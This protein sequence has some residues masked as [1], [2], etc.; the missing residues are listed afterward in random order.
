[1]SNALAIATVAGAAIL[2]WVLFLYRKRKLKVDQALLWMLVSI[3]MI[4]L[5]TWTG[6]LVSINLVVGAARTSDVVLAAFVAFLIVVSI[7]YSMKIS[8]LS[9]QTRKVA[10]EIAVLKTMKSE[11]NAVEALS[12]GRQEES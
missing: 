9:E 12:G 6:L 3:A 8:E 5:S 11:V 2:T 4:L 7:Y 10:Q 1:M